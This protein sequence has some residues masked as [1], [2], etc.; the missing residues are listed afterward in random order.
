MYVIVAG[1]GLSARQV[2]GKLVENK[3]TVVA[4]DINPKTCK[5]IR[6]EIGV[7]SIQGNATDA[8]V[9]KRAGARRADV[10]VCMMNS[11]ADNAAC[12][13]AGKSMGIKRVIGRLKYR[14]PEDVYRLDGM[15]TIVHIADIL[16]DQ[17]I[18][19]IEQPRVKKIMTFQAGKAE[20]YAVRIPEK[21]RSI[22]IKISEIVKQRAFPKECI[23]IGIYRESTGEYIIPRGEREFQEEDTVF[24]MLREKDISRITDLLMKKG[25][26]LWQT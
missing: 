1:A 15:D 18:A 13:K 4:I 6:S 7:R 14:Q 12:A 20:I 23:F 2:I 5:V 9:L 10:L 11:V 17:I 21:A 19:E 25:H 3:H 22:G 16:A 8:K 24:I 26:Y